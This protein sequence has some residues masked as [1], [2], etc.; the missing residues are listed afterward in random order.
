M[1]NLPHFVVRLLG[2]LLME[3]RTRL[4]TILS[5][6]SSAILPRMPD[7]RSPQ[8]PAEPRWETASVL[9]GRDRWW[10]RETPPILSME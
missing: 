1:D 9:V 8:F 4:E 2:S 5:V 6:I 10:F 3:D 7:R